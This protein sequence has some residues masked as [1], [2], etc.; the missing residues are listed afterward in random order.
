MLT[1]LTLWR[2]REFVLD[3]VDSGGECHG[4]GEVRVRGTT[5][6]ARFDQR[7]LERNAVLCLLRFHPLHQTDALKAM[8]AFDLRVPVGQVSSNG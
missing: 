8:S 4:G 3:A 6:D 7:R 2:R 1:S 5:R